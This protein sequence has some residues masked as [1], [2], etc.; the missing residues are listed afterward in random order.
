MAE[1]S[2]DSRDYHFVFILCMAYSG[3][4][5]L[6]KV[7]NSARNSMILHPIAEGQYL[8]PGMRG[9]DRRDPNKRI[10]W[11]SVKTTWLSRVNM[12]ESLAGKID[13]VIEKSP[14][15]IFRLD[16]LVTAFPN[17]SLITFNRN[18][19]ARSASHLYRMH[20]SLHKLG[21]EGRL[22]RLRKGV[23]NWI[24]VSTQI[25]KWADKEQTVNLTYEQFCQDPQLEVSKIMDSIPHLQGIDV[26]VPVKVKDYPPQTISNQNRRQVARLSEQEKCMIGEE[27]SGY[28]DLLQFFGYT[29]AWQKSLEEGGAC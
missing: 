4:T 15:H 18:P 6:A 25:K 13:V 19:Y 1:C 26:D 9:V 16:Q 17:N 7:L 20:A 2:L 23:H 5:V 24:D 10:E 11:D 29:S 28:E 14:P 12:V 8:V 22:D 3:S 27:L 21:T